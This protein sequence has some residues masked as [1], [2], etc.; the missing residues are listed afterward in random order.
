MGTNYYWV[1]PSEPPCEVCGRFDAD[2][3]IHIGKRSNGWKFSLHVQHG[4]APDDLDGWV[5]LFSEPGTF[6][7]DEYGERHEPEWMLDTIR[8]WGKRFESPRSHSVYVQLD[9][10]DNGDYDLARYEFS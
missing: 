9:A 4:D 3:R 10:T 2:E 7:V 8:N 5:K 1:R 6:I